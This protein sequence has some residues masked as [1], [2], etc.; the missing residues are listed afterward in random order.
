M[1]TLSVGGN[2]IDFKGILFNCI[3]ESTEFGRSPTKPCD[4]QRQETHALLNS[5]D[6]VNKIDHLIKKIVNQGRAGTISDDFR[7][8]VTGFPEF[9]NEVDPG[10]NTVTFARTAN[11]VPD[12]KDHIMMTTDLRED[13]NSMSVALNA[14]IQN[15]VFIN[16]GTNVKFI[17]IQAGGLLDGHR[18][19]EPGVVEPDQNNQNLWIWHYPY[20]ENEDANPP[21]DLQI[22]LNATEQITQG[23]DISAL[24]V[25]FPNISTFQDALWDAVNEGEVDTQSGNPPNEDAWDA[26]KDFI[27]P[28]AKLFHPQVAYHSAIRDLVLKQFLEDTQPSTGVGTGPCVPVGGLFDPQVLRILPLG[29]SIVYGTD[30]SDGN[31]F[32]EDLRSQLVANG[33]SVN[34]VGQVQAGSMIDNDVSGFPG[35]RIEQVA[36]LMEN[37][38]P[39]LPNL[40]LIHVGQFLGVSLPLPYVSRVANSLK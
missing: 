24:G 26:W 21:P 27:G 4:Q 35:L 29:A 23:L 3:I 8:Y 20:K 25:K 14:A 10:C 38:L 28:R 19:C 30:S 40:I 37:A 1:A 15:A 9:F 7:L 39:W 32:R 33:A 6:L 2:D 18:F 17:D 11:P 31:G 16:E 36:P 34:Y 5:P 13:Y 12:G 22:L